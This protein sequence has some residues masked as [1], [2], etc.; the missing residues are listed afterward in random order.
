MAVAQLPL[1]VEVWSPSTGDYDFDAKVPIYQQR[2][3]LEIWCIHPYERTLT[4][5]RRQP[6]GSYEETMYRDGTITPVALPAVTIDLDTL[7]DT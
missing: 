2:G 1:I 7:L 5:W 6:E 3:D 4:A